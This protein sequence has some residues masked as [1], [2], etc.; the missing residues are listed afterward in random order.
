MQ[1]CSPVLW[2]EN[3]PLLAA[4]AERVI[5]IGPGRPLRGFFRSIGVKV[6]SVSTLKIAR[7]LLS[8]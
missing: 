1:V 3:M 8:D 2:N 4:A 5:E 6:L 7:E